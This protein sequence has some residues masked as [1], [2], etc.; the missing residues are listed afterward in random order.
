MEVFFSIC[1]N[2]EQGQKAI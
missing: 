2:S 1:F